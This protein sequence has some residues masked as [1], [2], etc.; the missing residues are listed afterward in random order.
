AICPNR[1]STVRNV[2]DSSIRW[3][4]AANSKGWNLIAAFNFPVLCFWK[5]SW[6][7]REDPRPQE[8]NDLAKTQV[9]GHHL[10]LMNNGAGNE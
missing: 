5:V 4:F 6:G 2:D 3:Y 10:D 9:K 7:T 1:W 8:K